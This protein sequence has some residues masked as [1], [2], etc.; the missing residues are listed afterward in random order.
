MQTQRSY[1]RR[2]WAGALVLGGLLGVAA[3]VSSCGGRDESLVAPGVEPQL[4]VTSAVTSDA[5]LQRLLF[6]GVPLAGPSQRYLQ[7]YQGNPTPDGRHAGVDY[8][9]T[10][11]VYAP[12]DGILRHAST[13]C[14]SVVLEDARPLSTWPGDIRPPRHIFLHMKDV[15][16][17]GRV[18]QR[19]SAGTL[20]G[21]SSMVA[22]GGC[23]V[24]GAHLHYEI[25]RNYAGTSAVYRTSCD[26]QRGCT[27]ETLTYD[28]YRF[29]Y[30]AT[31]TS[32]TL[33]V[34]VSGPG[35]V[36]SSPSGISCGAGT[37][38]A[39]FVNNAVMTL[40]A[41]PVSGASF[42][43]WT[44][45][46]SG[47]S[48]CVLAMSANRSATATF[49]SPPPAEAIVD[50]RSASFS[51]SG[52]PAYWKEAG[53]GWGGHM[54]WTYSDQ[55]RVDNQGT[56]R[57]VLPGVGDYTVS[58]YIPAN[59]ATTRAATYTIY[60]AGR[61][62]TRVIDQMSYSNVWVPLGRFSFRADGSEFVRLVDRTGESNSSRRMVGFDAVRFAR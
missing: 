14:G 54:F 1:T 53:I 10:R 51:R 32:R 50:D 58:V 43:G 34:T 31:P 7:Y 12:V 38:Q 9:G 30:S 52:T 41:T 36:V 56:W 15:K 22:G 13:T 45:D 26:G 35:A 17:L 46:C 21:T 28:P 23:V 25:R 19:I 60:H 42:T 61:T 59:Y 57:P 4:S 39:T 27:T 37:C 44:G 6:N 8:S 3:L 24:T 16:V 62:E 18:G 48:A 11:G 2:R 49:T 5:D 20:L 33:S 47:R 29:P 40:T 55:S